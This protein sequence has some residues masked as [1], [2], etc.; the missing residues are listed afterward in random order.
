MESPLFEEN[1]TQ[2]CSGS[3]KSSACH[4][5]HQCG[6][7]KEGND[8]RLIYG[9]EKGASQSR[10]TL[11]E[12]LT[13]K[14]VEAPYSSLKKTYS[15]ENVPLTSTVSNDKSLHSRKGGSTNTTAQMKSMSFGSL[16]SVISNKK[17]L[18]H[19]PAENTNPLT[20]G[21]EED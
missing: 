6:P 9:N 8:S 5:P 11:K 18:G 3:R 7:R 19:V 2:N 13:S 4:I 21:N 20:T 15:A 16:I 12:P 1:R 14:G 17:V 10:L